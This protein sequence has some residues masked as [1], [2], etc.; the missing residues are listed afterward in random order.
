MKTVQRLPRSTGCWAIRL[1]SAKDWMSVS[2]PAA[3]VWRKDP[4]PDEQASLTEMESMTWSTTRRYF[5]SWPPM[6]MMAVTP[7]SR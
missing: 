3:K 1:M 7:G 4:H 6:S 5:M 2:I